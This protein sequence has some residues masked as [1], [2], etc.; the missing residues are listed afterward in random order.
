MVVLLVLA[1]AA[2]AREP[3]F[4]QDIRDFPV[5][6][7]SLLV[8]PPVSGADSQTGQKLAENMAWGLREAGYPAIFA[9]SPDSQNPILQGYVDE[10]EFGQEIVWVSMRW[11]LLD[12]PSDRATG[13]RP[14]AGSYRHQVATTVDEWV[15]LSRR[16]VSMII[17]EAVPALN[18]F[19]APLIFP[20]GPPVEVALG[21]V[22]DNQLA[23]LGPLDGE[24]TVFIGG[25][26]PEAA[27]VQEAGNSGQLR[28]AQFDP[29]FE[30]ATADPLPSS[31]PSI[32]DI[33]QAPAAPKAEMAPAG[34]SGEA[35]L[36]T[37][38]G[39]VTQNDTT[40]LPS[41]ADILRPAPSK[42]EA[43]VPVPPPPPEPP[44]PVAADEEVMPVVKPTAV[45][46]QAAQTTVA[47]PAPAEESPFS[48]IDETILN[49]SEG[50]VLT[51][52]SAALV[53]TDPWL[54]IDEPV[55]VEVEAEAQ[56][57]QPTSTETVVEA[58]S[59]DVAAA[60]SPPL[61]PSPPAADPAIPDAVIDTL[62]QPVSETVVA[63]TP[64]AAPEPEPEPQYVANSGV[65]AGVL[66]ATAAPN[67]GRPIFVIQQVQG[68]P[69][70]GNTA[71][72]AAIA[73]SLRQMDASVTNDPSQATHVVQGSVRVDSPFAG[74][75]KVR[76]VWR[77]T[78][79]DGQVTGQ[80]VQENQ[81]PQG[82][83]D[84]IWGGTAGAVANAAVAGIERLFVKPV[85]ASQ[86]E[87]LSQPDLPHV[88]ND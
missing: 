34:T 65:S 49:L 67:A 7:G 13:L 3:V 84:G 14:V 29:T 72:T 24:A 88:G 40:G 54:T 87:G 79:I 19:A 53:T 27:T 36:P 83:L 28:F 38:S 43:A 22:G 73:Q 39:A 2:C 45:E 42:P 75:Q 59:D 16:T 37:P 21:D 23:A 69:G 68:A 64:A 18:G 35:T 32:I 82:S 31:S 47:A 51:P 5:G 62:P 4:V 6:D 25:D 46:R 63:E 12:V 80:A 48:S 15:I 57:I 26:P 11:T 30:P 61:P 9:D 44:L 50:Y 41:V 70:D 58:S 17:A 56:T 81:V 86:H 71:L 66:N 55:V 8:V 1:L 74:R 33:P 85:A 76:I 52:E 10:V 60:D 78:G 77:V 20:D